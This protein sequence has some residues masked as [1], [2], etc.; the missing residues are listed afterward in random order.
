MQLIGK[1][2]I[3]AGIIV[4]II[5]FI[6]WVFGHKMSWIGN[7]PGDIKIEKEN[8]KIYF[9]IITMILVSIALSLIAWLI[10]KFL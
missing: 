10:R 7:L 3:L 6:L 1:Y 8:V 9:P 4:I 5:G 2:L